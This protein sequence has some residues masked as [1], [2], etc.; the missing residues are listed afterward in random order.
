MAKK[1]EIDDTCDDAAASPMDESVTLESL[2]GRSTLGADGAASSLVA[3]PLDVEAAAAPLDPLLAD[4]SFRNSLKAD[5]MSL[6][7]IKNVTRK[8][9]TKAFLQIKITRFQF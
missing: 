1:R 8:F 7:F 3:P 6:R 9:K 5:M 2:L 4:V